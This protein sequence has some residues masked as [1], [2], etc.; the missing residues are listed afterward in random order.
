MVRHGPPGVVGRGGLREPDVSRVPREPNAQSM[1]SR[2][3]IR[4]RAVLMRYAPRFI[5]AS[6]SSPKRPPVSGCSGA[7]TVTTSQCR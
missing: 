4:A 6:S 5:V 7:L 2:S 3:A 1:A